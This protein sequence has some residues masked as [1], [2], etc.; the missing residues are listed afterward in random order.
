MARKPSALAR[1]LLRNFPKGKRG[2]RGTRRRRK[3]ARTAGSAAPQAA[4]TAAPGAD[5][6]VPTEE[7]LDE[8]LAGAVESD[9]IEVVGD[10]DRGAVEES[11]ADA[12]DA[13]PG[14]AG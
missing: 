5:G 8:A 4:A 12:L 11:V 9:G 10:E 7:V 14:S 6:A 1:E 13:E 2:G 3:G